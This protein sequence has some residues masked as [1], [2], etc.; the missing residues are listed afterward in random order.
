VEVFV[1][2]TLRHNKKND[3]LEDLEEDQILER[4]GDCIVPKYE[5]EKDVGSMG[6]Q[7]EEELYKQAM[8]IYCD[9]QSGDA[10]RDDYEWP[11][12]S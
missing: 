10:Y 6:Q 5:S 2:P 9:L 1:D 8:K 11:T 7:R 12:L 4:H 3:N